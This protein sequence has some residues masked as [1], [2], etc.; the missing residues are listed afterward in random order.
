[1]VVPNLSTPAGAGRTLP[2]RGGVG[3]AVLD[4]DRQSD[5]SFRLGSYAAPVALAGLLAG[6][7]AAN[8]LVLGLLAAVPVAVAYTLGWAVSGGVGGALLMAVF[9][10][11]FGLVVGLGAGTVLA[12]LTRRPAHG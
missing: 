12:N 5:P 6:R 3:R 9:S 11:G 2:T 10:G 7:A 1:V 8:P 4:R